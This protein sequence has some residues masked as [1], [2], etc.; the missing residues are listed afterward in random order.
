MFHPC[1]R[2]TV[3]GW[4]F[5]KTNLPCRVLEDQ[6]LR[7]YVQ[8]YV[9][10]YGTIH[11]SRWSGSYA[12]RRTD[13]KCRRGWRGW[14]GKKERQKGEPLRSTGADF[15]NGSFLIPPQRFFFFRSLVFD[16]VLTP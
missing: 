6:G 10:T 7:G 15:K 14:W 5:L 3:A 11:P 9:Y 12:H 16:T 2:L 13:W 8:A 4:G 1:R